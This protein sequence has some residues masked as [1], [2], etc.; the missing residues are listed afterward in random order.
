MTEHRFITVYR[1]MDYGD[2]ED[3]TLSHLGMRC[4]VIFTRSEFSLSQGYPQFRADPEGSSVVVAIKN[5]QFESGPY[6]VIEQTVD[7]HG[8][9]Y[10]QIARELAAEIAGVLEVLAPSIVREKVFEGVVS[11]N[12]SIAMS[13]DGPIM[14]SP[15]KSIKLRSLAQELCERHSEIANLSPHDRGRFR[16]ASRWF[17]K[18]LQTYDLVDKFL[19]LYVALEVHPAANTS[20]V[21]MA[22]RDYLR[23]NLFPALTASEIKVRLQLGQLAGYRAKIVHDG[24]VDLDDTS[25]KELT[26]HIRRAEAMVR[27]CLGVLIGLPD[28]DLLKKWIVDVT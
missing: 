20:D 24:L 16:L 14:I 13:L 23:A 9:P 25:G 2:Q 1:L 17:F 10:R 4:S 12:E 22:L 7:L 27:A 15:I 18:S 5:I 26:G 19:S 28:P 21:P 8:A 6:L 3:L 11:T